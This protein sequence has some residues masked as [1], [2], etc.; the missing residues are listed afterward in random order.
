MK[1]LV[2]SDAHGNIRFLSRALQLHRDTEGVFFLGDGLE[3]I[4]PI[5]QQFPIPFY[6][7]R[8]NCDF[9]IGT[10]TTNVLQCMEHKIL[11]THGHA[12]QVKSGSERIK[13]A[14][15]DRGA[16]IILFG[17]THHA[18]TQYDDGLYLMNPGSIGMDSRGV[19]YGII[20]LS[21]QGV[22]LSNAVIKR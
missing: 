13:Q 22:M 18:M 16:D 10:P 17:H 7:V 15:R 3:Q 12:Y 11:Y 21:K 8:G 1:F 19:A 4:E 20:E 6:C 14:A 9:A 5:K 2:F